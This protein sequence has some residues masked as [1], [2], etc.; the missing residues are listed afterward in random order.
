MSSKSDFGTVHR[1]KRFL[2]VLEPTWQED[3]LSDDDISVPPEIDV[4]PDDADIDAGETEAA[5]KEENRWNDLDLESF[6]P[7]E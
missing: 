1:P 5:K 4:P 7:N 6:R 2:D 3:T